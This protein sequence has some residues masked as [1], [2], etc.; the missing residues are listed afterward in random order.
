ML[1]PEPDK[2]TTWI[3]VFTLHKTYLCYSEIITPEGDTPYKEVSIGSHALHYIARLEAQKA[4]EN[5]KYRGRLECLRRL[6]VY[7]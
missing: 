4:S 2:F 1:P 6:V 5:R 3:Q 7:R